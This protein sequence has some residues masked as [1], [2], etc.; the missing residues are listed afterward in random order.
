MDN[1]WLI[2]LERRIKWEG[3]SQWKIKE[4]K[5]VGGKHQ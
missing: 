2:R 1:L 4:M 5:R 3:E